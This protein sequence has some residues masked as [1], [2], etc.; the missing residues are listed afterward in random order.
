[1]QQLSSY[2]VDIVYFGPLHIVSLTILKRVYEGEIF[3]NL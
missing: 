2:L 1:M 3:T